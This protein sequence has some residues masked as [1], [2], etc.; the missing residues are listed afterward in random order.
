MQILKLALAIEHDVGACTPDSKQQIA[1]R[2]QFEKLFWHSEGT[3]TEHGDG[4]HGLRRYV[5]ILSRSE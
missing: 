5:V 3:N 2:V 4:L 1:Q